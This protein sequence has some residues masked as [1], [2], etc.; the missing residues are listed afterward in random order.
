MTAAASAAGRRGRKQAGSAGA[1]APP[2]G[3]LIAF[4]LASVLLQY[5]TMA[6]FDGLAILMPRLVL[7]PHA[8]PETRCAGILTGCAP[9]PLTTWPGTT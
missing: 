9:R 6:L 3:N 8:L 2:D 7:S 5:R 4:K 1:P